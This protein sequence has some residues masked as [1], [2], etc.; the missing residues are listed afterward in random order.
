MA[1]PNLKEMRHSLEAY[2]IH[3][4]LQFFSLYRNDTPWI[5]QH[6]PE[7]SMPLSYIPEN[8]TITGPIVVSSVPAEEQ[9]EELVLWLRKLPTVLINLGSSTQYDESRVISMVAAIAESLEAR[10]D[11]QFIWKYRLSSNMNTTI[12]DYIRPVQEYIKNGRLR[13]TRW[14]TVD[15]A[16]LLESGL[17]TASVHHG[18]ANCY[19]EAVGYVTLSMLLTSGPMPSFLIL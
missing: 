10:P 3:K 14:L 13:I 16:S 8:V 15:P 4:P 9:D 19:W 5:T 6:V 12:D 11:L 18:G 1:L 17:V 2:G 7:A